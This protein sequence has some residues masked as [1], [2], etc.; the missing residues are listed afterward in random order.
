MTI[1]LPFYRSL[2]A[3]AITATVFAAQDG[4]SPRSDSFN[5]QPSSAP[6][7]AIPLL[8]TTDPSYRLLAGDTI[9]VTVSTRSN[10]IEHSSNQT[11]AQTGDV[12]LPW[13]DKEIAVEG[14]SVR[15]AERFL[16]KLYQDQGLLKSPVVSVKVAVYFPRE[17]NV[18]GAVLRPG[19]HPFPADTVSLD[20][21]KVIMMAGGFS[22]VAKQNAVTI[23]H[24]EKNG[25]EKPREYDLEGIISGRRKPGRESGE[26]L[27]YPG[28]RIH[29]PERLF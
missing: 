6:A 2:I 24:R 8:T 18:T 7:N 5:S 26:V 27:I 17:I 14:K 19:T 12:R 10:K 23:F 20:I 3:F 16:E 28:D 11:I 13:I 15:E 25:Q 4:G 9:V 21:V 29:V 22:P 1:I